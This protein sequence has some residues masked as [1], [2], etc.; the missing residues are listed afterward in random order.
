MGLLIKNSE[1]IKS[2]KVL[3]PICLL[4][5]FLLCS[6]FSVAKSKNDSILAPTTLEEVKAL[7]EQQ[8]TE[9]NEMKP[10]LKRL[11]KSEKDL[12]LIIAALEKNSPLA[13]Q[14][15]EQ[16]LLNENTFLPPENEKV[17]KSSTST[18][19]TAAPIAETLATEIPMIETGHALGL[20]KSPVLPTTKSKTV[21]NVVQIGIHIASYKKTSS[22]EKGW[23][24]LVKKY[25]GQLTRKIPF[26]YQVSVEDVLYTRLVAG[27]FNSVLSAQQACME[28]KSKN[29]YCQVISYKVATNNR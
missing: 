26:Y 8:V 6:P 7:L 5:C 25:S 4:C 10:A 22:V 3:K 19:K 24:L 11:I 21:K 23:K 2:R 14:P 15:S 9:W 13:S 28:M 27:S 29:Q 1:Y 16:Q 17:I 18:V 20:K 12:A